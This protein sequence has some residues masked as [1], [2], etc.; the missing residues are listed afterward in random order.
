MKRIKTEISMVATKCDILCDLYPHLSRDESI[1]LAESIINSSY[2]IKGHSG[3]FILTYRHPY[4]TKL[5]STNSSTELKHYYMSW[6]CCPHIIMEPF[7]EVKCRIN[8]LIYEADIKS[9]IPR[10]I[11]K[12]KNI[13][14]TADIDQ[15]EHETVRYIYE[16]KWLTSFFK[17]NPVGECYNPRIL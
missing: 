9:V 11:Y 16:A 7:E 13:E 2:E 14:P 1:E 12:I 17:R 4:S 5:Y 8:T 15:E 6:T 10:L 3:K